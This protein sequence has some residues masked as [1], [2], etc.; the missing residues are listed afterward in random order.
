MKNTETTKCF[1]HTSTKT[2]GNMFQFQIVVFNIFSR[3][4]LFKMYE[5]Q[6]VYDSFVYMIDIQN[7][8]KICRKYLLSGTNKYMLYT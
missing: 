7:R 6:L 8:F 3:I 1:V 2:I 4:G 5:T